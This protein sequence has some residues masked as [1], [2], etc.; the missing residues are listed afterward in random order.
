[1]FNKNSKKKYE[2]FNM[3]FIGYGPT[4]ESI[5]LQKEGIKYNPDLVIFNIYVMNDMIKPDYGSAGHIS[6]E[7]F[8]ND[9]INESSLKVTK[10]Q[11]L[12]DFISRNFFT[13]SFL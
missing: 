9:E 1:M 12:K 11:K 13:Y 8:L 7:V 10:I 3:A 2:V 4:P 6:K 5:F